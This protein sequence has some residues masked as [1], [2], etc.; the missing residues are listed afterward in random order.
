DVIGDAPGI[1]GGVVEESE[2]VLRTLLQAEL[3]RPGAKCVFIARRRQDFAFELAPV[4]GIVVVLQAKLAQAEAQTFTD[5]FYEFAKH[6]FG[7]ILWLIVY[8]TA[9]ERKS[10]IPFE[11]SIR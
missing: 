8:H 4:T 9:A 5:L 7:F 11:T 10:Q 6:R 3:L 1:H 2:P